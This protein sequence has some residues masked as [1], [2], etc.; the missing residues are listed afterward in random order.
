MKD[1]TKFAYACPSVEV[2][3]LDTEDVICT[4][5]LKEATFFLGEKSWQ[6]GWVSKLTRMTGQTSQTGME[7]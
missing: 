5:P 7:D 6:S 3:H 4:S 1:R 2:L